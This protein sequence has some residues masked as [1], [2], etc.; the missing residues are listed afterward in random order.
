MAKAY[1]IK[2]RVDANGKAAV[3]ELTR[4]E[5]RSA[6]SAS[7]PSAQPPRRTS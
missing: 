5:K 6:M 2:L 4:V 7:P 3:T 1:E